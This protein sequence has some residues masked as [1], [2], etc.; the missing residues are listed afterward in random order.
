MRNL[1]ALPEKLLPDRLSRGLLSNDVIENYKKPVIIVG[2]VVGSIVVGTLVVRNIYFNKINDLVEETRRRE[3]ERAIKVQSDA[4]KPIGLVREQQ[5]SN[6]VPNTPNEPRSPGLS[7]LMDQISQQGNSLSVDRVS[8]NSHLARRKPRNMNSICSHQMNVEIDHPVELV[9]FSTHYVKRALKLLEDLKAR[10]R[11]T[12]PSD[13]AFATRPT[14]Q[15]TPGTVPHCQLTERLCSLSQLIL[16]YPFPALPLF[17]QT[18]FEVQN[19]DEFE[20]IIL[21]AQSLI[22]RI[23]SFAKNSQAAIEQ[24]QNVSLNARK[25]A[26]L[27]LNFCPKLILRECHNH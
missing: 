19:S 4:A 2:T 3:N 20:G 9:M 17:T 27:L 24:Q 10:N 6:S 21:D 22:E 8:L 7:V 26:K 14:A 15:L 13:S 23:Q 16:I 25:L 11:G 5:Q 18:E 1:F 12:N